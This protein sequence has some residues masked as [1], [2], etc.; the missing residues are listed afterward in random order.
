MDYSLDWM[1]IRN[2]RAQH[3]TNFSIIESESPIARE[4][5]SNKLL[6]IPPLMSSI[7]WNSS[8]ETT[9]QPLGDM[10]SIRGRFS[11]PLKDYE[12]RS[13]DIVKHSHHHK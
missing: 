1:H 13:N 12:A 9:A 8:A 11:P 7:D 3:G 5:Q 4:L 2:E 10:V 6:D